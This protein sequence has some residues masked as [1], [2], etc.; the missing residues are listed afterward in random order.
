M[1]IQTVFEGY[2]INTKDKLRKNQLKYDLKIPMAHAAGNPQTLFAL[3]SAVAAPA[4]AGSPA[5]A[6]T[7]MHLAQH[8]D[9]W[10]DTTHLL[11]KHFVG[12]KQVVRGGMMD[13]LS[14]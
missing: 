7:F 9:L 2:R 6:L 10:K 1:G 11:M 5:A 13:L 8:F 4:T 14:A 3:E 12:H